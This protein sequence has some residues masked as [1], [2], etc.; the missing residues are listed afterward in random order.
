MGGAC[1]SLDA[2][3][4]EARQ[5]R[6]LGPRGRRGAPAGLEPAGVRAEGRLRP[7][8]RGAHAAAARRA[9]TRARGRGLAQPAFCLPRDRVQPRGRGRRPRSRAAG[10]ARARRR[11]RALACPQRLPGPRLLPCRRASRRHGVPGP[12]PAREHLERV[13]PAR[14]GARGRARR[15]AGGAVTA[16]FRNEPTLEL[17]KA[18]ARGSLLDALRALEPRLPLTVPVLIGENSRQSTVDSRLESTDPGKPERLV[19][20]AGV[21]TAE[22]VDAAVEAAGRGFRQWRDMDR[23]TVLLRAAQ[24]LRERRLEIAALEVRECAKPW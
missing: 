6:L 3:R 2:D 8:L 22:D 21:A 20:V 16:P 18:S 1:P 23:T 14:A 4:R 11:P 12:A 24:I 9:A 10:A 13:L 5:G 19:A 17:R 7:Q 15:T